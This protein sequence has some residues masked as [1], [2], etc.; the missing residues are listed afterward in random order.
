M[1]IMQFR[2]EQR[3]KKVQEES[4]IMYQ[5]EIDYQSLRN[6]GGSNPGAK[7]KMVF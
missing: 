3:N 4:R 1:G 7:M 2:A 5:L 6:K